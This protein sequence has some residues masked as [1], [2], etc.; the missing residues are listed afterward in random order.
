MSYWKPTGVG[1]R[2]HDFVKTPA[3]TRQELRDRIGQI[4]IGLVFLFNVQCAIA[5]IFTPD[6]Y[7]PGF[8]VS[9]VMGAGIVRGMGLLFLMWNVPYLVALINPV[10]Y[11]I[12]LYEAVAMQAIGFAGESLLLATF[13]PGHAL[14]RATLWRFI[15]FDGCGLLALILAAWLTND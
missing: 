14:I 5:F 6:T 1:Y 10:K 13:P 9:G 3:K 15:L 8:E 11:R 2:G 4:L 7:S 12:S